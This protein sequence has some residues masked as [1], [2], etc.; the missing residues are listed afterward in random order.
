MR[1]TTRDP[2]T[3]NDVADPR[4]APF[5]V[6]GEGEGALVI[7]FESERSRQTYLQIPVRV[8]TP[9]S[10]KLYRQIEDYDKTIWDTVLWD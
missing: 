6:E 7:Y 5:V 3:G 2:M 1:V 10:T 4:L 9:R 8:P